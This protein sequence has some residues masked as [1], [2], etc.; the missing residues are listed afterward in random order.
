[1]PLDILQGVLIHP[2]IVA[3]VTPLSA[4]RKEGIVF[5]AQFQNPLYG[6]P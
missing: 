4:M 3:L 2:D 1:M 5:F 6:L